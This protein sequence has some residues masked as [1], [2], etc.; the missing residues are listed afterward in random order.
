MQVFDPSLSSS[1]LFADEVETSVN[2]G[3]GLG[4]I[5]LQ[6][7]WADK[8][9]DSGIISKRIEFLLNRSVLLLLRFECLACVYGGLEICNWN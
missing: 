6:Q 3:C 8:L 7:H 9:I 5:L 2:S 4:L 1:D